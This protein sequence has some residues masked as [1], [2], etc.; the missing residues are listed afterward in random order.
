MSARVLSGSGSYDGCIIKQFS[1]PST[2]SITVPIFTSGEGDEV[3]YQT[4]ITGTI[5]A[6]TPTSI[7]IGSGT[8]SISDL[9]GPFTVKNINVS[10]KTLITLMYDSEN[11]D[12]A[13]E[14]VVDGATVY[15]YNDADGYYAPGSLTITVEEDVIKIN[16]TTYTQGDSITGKFV[17]DGV[18]YSETVFKF[19]SVGGTSSI[20]IVE[21]D[22]GKPVYE[23]FNINEFISLDSSVK[24][25]DTVRFEGDPQDNPPALDLKISIS[26]NATVRQCTYK[27]KANAIP[28]SITRFNIRGTNGSL[29]KFA[30]ANVDVPN[31]YYTDTYGIKLDSESGGVKIIEDSGSTGF[32]DDYK[33]GKLDSV[34]FKWKYSALLVKAFRGG[35]DSRIRSTHQVSAAYLF[36]ANFNTTYGVELTDDSSYTVKEIIE[37]SSIFTPEE[38]EMILNN[39][40]ILESVIDVPEDIDVKQAMNDL[41]IER[42]YNGIPEGKRPVGYGSGFQVY[43][44]VGT[45][46]YEENLKVYESMSSRFDNTNFSCDIGWWEEGG[47]KYTYPK[48][49]IESLFSFCDAAGNI[50]KPFVLAATTISPDRYTS[51]SPAIEGNEWELKEEIYN[52]GANVWCID[53][54]NNLQRQFQHTFS[55]IDESSSMVQESNQRTLNVLVKTIERIVEKY[56]FQVD[57]D[58]VWKTAIDECNTKFVG[59]K[60]N[61]V[62]DYNIERRVMEAPDGTAISTLYVTVSFRNLILQIPVI[63]NIE[64]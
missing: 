19:N 3:Y 63:V 60:G 10:T 52:K 23:R 22:D 20:S 25:L 21:S 18:K 29:Y 55:S 37:S 14:T 64:K 13:V 58:G 26:D 15:I 6:E 24:T 62:K 17:H 38:K 42:N 46:D 51:Y 45:G 27:A 40:E 47:F 1:A 36:D 2:G 16:D 4:N 41:A 54:N 35:F 28:E 34:V 33:N 8:Y 31:D 12:F 56:I 43:F 53:S 5:S 59:W 39:P 32:F 49:I 50:N 57:E 9:I 7:T 11:T 30:K 61:I 44:D 48:R